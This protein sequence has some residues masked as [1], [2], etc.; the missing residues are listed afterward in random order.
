MATFELREKGEVRVIRCGGFARFC[1]KEL[2]N[3][4]NFASDNM[5]L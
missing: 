3:T 5:R 1:S 4:E 2:Q